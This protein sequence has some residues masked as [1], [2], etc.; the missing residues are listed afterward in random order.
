[1]SVWSRGMIDMDALKAKIPGWSVS[2]AGEGESWKAWSPTHDR[3]G[4]EVSAA[5]PSELVDRVIAL[6]AVIAVAAEVA[7]HAPDRD[8]AGLWPPPGLAALRAK[9]GKGEPPSS[10]PEPSHGKDAPQTETPPPPRMRPPGPDTSRG[11]ICSTCGGVNLRPNGPS[12]MVCND[13]GS[14]G[15]CG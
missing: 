1:M 14:S 8:V 5:D 13:C 6:Q 15:A 3:D 12:C 11:E 10:A 2:E 9:L 4:I 7:L